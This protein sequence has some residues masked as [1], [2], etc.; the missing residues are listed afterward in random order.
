[1]TLKINDIAIAAF[2]LRPKEM[3]ERNF[4]QSGGRRERRDVPADAFLHLVGPHHH[5]QCIPPNQALNAA[6]HL[7]APRK[8]RLLP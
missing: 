8:W 2:R 6:F 3:V 7:L 4:I 1:M 5:G